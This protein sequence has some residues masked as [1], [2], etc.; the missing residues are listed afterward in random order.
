MSKEAKQPLSVLTGEQLSSVVF[1]QDYIQLVFDG[2]TLT[3]I[4]LPVIKFGD[5]CYKWGDPG[6]C[7]S[8]C[9]RIAKTVRLAYVVEEKEI[10]IEFDDGVSILISLR[11]EDYRAA[12]A[13]MFTN[14]TDTWVW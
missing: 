6:Y 12:E 1:V 8:L 11:P 2:P 4:T 13:A 10:H 5:D 7:E 14:G 3:A 9:G